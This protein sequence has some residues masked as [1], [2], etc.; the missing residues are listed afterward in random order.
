MN[1]EEDNENGKQGR[2]L[3]DVVAG[4]SI[5]AM[6]GSILV[7]QFLKTQS[8]EKAA[9]KLERFWTNQLSVKNLDISELSK[10]WYDEWTK[11]NPTTASEEAARRYYS[12]KKLLSNQV[13]NNM[14][15]LCDKI[16]DNKFFDN[17]L[18]GNDWYL[19]STKPLQESIE[20][21]AKFPIATTFL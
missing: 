5:G 9:D 6:N 7:S 20:K 14:Y 21:Y 4:T 16:V 8:W 10:P 18:L 17:S 13:A 1:M 2:L 11:R 12:V 3:F 19:H 15:Y